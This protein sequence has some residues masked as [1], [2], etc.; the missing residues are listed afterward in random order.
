MLKRA[1]PIILAAVVIAP[2]LAQRQT[3]NTTQI[4][5]P[6]FKGAGSFRRK[7]SARTFTRKVSK[8]SSPATKRRRARSGSARSISTRTTRKPSA[9]GDARC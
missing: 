1:L 6:T 4:F 2:V 5:S 8:P 3:Q 9:Q 7:S